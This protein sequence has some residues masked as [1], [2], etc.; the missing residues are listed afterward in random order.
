MGSFC[1][2]PMSVEMREDNDTMAVWEC[3]P[4]LINKVKL[5]NKKNGGMIYMT[6]L[7]FYRNITHLI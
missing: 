5:T 7:S 3:L 6:S 4:G 1:L 2:V